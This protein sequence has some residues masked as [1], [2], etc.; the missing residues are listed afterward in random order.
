MTKRRR[1][2]ASD[3]EDWLCGAI[4]EELDTDAVAHLLALLVRM[5]SHRL[6]EEQSM[7]RTGLGIAHAVRLRCEDIIAANA[8]ADAAEDGIGV[9]ADHTADDKRQRALRARKS[10]VARLLCDVFE[11]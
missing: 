5:A 6:T 3:D 1:L 8:A 9:Y 2:C 10:H 4:E 7:R 11:T